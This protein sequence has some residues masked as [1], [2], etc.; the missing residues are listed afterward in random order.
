MVRKAYEGNGSSSSKIAR[1]EGHPYLTK[2]QI[3]E[4]VCVCVCVYIYIYIYIYIMYICMYIC[5]SYYITNNSEI[6]ILETE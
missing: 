5:I 1:I 2:Q 4:V 6:L 3:Q